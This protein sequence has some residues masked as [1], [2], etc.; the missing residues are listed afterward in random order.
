MFSAFYNLKYLILK[1]RVFLA[2]SVLQNVD[3]VLSIVLFSA[4]AVI[5][6]K[7]FQ[8][9]IAKKKTSHLSACAAAWA[10]VLHH[11]GSQE[12]GDR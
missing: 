10:G 9:H 3:L 12:T 5:F 4:K 8:L 2:Y 11:D 6:Q 1:K 7:H